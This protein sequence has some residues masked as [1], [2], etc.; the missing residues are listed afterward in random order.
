VVD[1]W[2]KTGA[3]IDS[4]TQPYNQHNTRTNFQAKLPG[5]S[6]VWLDSKCM[7]SVLSV[8]LIE[9]RYLFTYCSS[10]E[11]EFIVHMRN[12][13][14]KFCRSSE[15]LYYYRTDLKNGIILEQTIDDNKSFYTDRQIACD[16]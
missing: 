10:I 16:K 13:S 14:L 9:D 12:G 11:P 8:A 1:W 15:G 7:V 5:L 4:G 2:T 6:N 3:K